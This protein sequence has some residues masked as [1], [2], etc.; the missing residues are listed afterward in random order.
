MKLTNFETQKKKTPL[1]WSLTH[2]WCF[3]PNPLLF[4]PKNETLDREA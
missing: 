1:K 3:F 4:N 2:A